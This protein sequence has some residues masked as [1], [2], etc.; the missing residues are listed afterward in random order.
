MIRDLR[1]VAL[2]LLLGCPNKD[3][4]D[5]GDTDAPDTGDTDTGP[6]TSAFA[7][8]PTIVDNT[9]AGLTAWLDVSFDAPLAVEV[10]I[11]NDDRT[12]TIDSPAALAHHVLMLGF[13]PETTHAI[14]VRARDAGG[15]VVA[16]QAL[17]HTGAPLPADF[18]TWELAVS[19]PERM[20]PGA[21]LVAFGDY[22]TFIDPQGFPVWF[23]PI[24]G[25]VHEATVLA[26]GNLI[27]VVNRTNVLEFDLAGSL[28]TQWRAARTSDQ[29][30]SAIPVDVNA[31]HHD[32]H[33]LPDGNFVGLSIER[34][35]IE[36]YPSSEPDPGAPPAPA[37]VAGDVVVEFTPEGAVV[38]SWPLLDLLDP[39]RIAFDS[40]VGNYWEDFEPW[41]GD[42]IKD[43]SHGNAVSY[44][45]ASDTLLVGLRHQDAII[46]FSRTTG[47][48][49]W[50]IAPP[51]N[52]PPELLEHV[53]L[54]AD[55]LG[56]IYPYH[57]H[58]AKFTPAG[59]V[60]A[61]DNGNNRASVGETPI[62][63]QD[64]FSRGLEL[65]LDLEAGTYD[66][67]WTYGQALVPSHY[68]GSLGDA[69]REPLTGNSVITFGNLASPDLGGVRLLEVTPSDEI[70][71][72][73]TLPYAQLT[74]YRSERLTGVIPGL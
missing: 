20:E 23:V 26:N 52:W 29:P 68:A 17:S 61:F 63:P 56:W 39:H 66:L 22:L 7:T 10:Q 40:V 54:P 34:R 13:R 44:D 51:A 59:T 30:A 4:D 43:W 25:A 18:F 2:A 65:A 45:P 3:K 11:S 9:T 28:V 32:I 48:L 57:M 74:T 35:W 47:A 64:N 36:D 69:D 19:T 72:D 53:L 12:W 41:K 38:R 70:V 42:E 16:E 8:G 49:Q 71:W 27:V 1:L 33:E 46:G 58:G 37:W 15:T 55:P 24:Q 73:L 60:M 31:L 67:V 50:I 5:P 6:D 14:V 62:A 21:T